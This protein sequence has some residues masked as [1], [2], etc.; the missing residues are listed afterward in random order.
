MES[1]KKHFDLSPDEMASMHDPVMIMRLANSFTDLLSICKHDTIINIKQEAFVLSSRIA[2]SLSF[3]EKE[4]VCTLFEENMKSYYEQT[5]GL[6]K[7][8]EDE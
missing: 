8:G 4:E 2:S 7:G 5:W 1:A 3:E 6:K